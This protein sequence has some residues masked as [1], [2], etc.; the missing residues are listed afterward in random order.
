MLKVTGHIQLFASEKYVSP[1]Y[2]KF[3]K[4]NENLSNLR[5]KFSLVSKKI[6]A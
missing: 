2:Y 6:E 5:C 1:S 3:T 4:L